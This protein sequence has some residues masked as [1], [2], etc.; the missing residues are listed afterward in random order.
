[1][2]DIATRAG[3]GVVAT[4][5][6]SIDGDG[7]YT[8]NGVALP[9]GVVTRGGSGDAVEWS[10]ELLKEAAE[11][12]NAEPM[13]SP[14][15]ID[16]ETGEGYPPDPADT[17]GRV[18]SAGYEPGVGVVYEA[19]LADAEIARKAAAGILDVSAVVLH[20]GKDP[21]D[22]GV[23][24]PTRAVFRGL[25]VVSKGAAPGN[26]I[27]MGESKQAALASLSAS[28]I[29]ERL[30]TGESEETTPDGYDA[31]SD[32]EQT[33]PGTSDGDSNMG[34]EN[35]NEALIQRIETLE[36]RVDEKD[37]KIDSLSADLESVESERDELSE[38]NESVAETLATVL[39]PHTPLST[40]EE[41]VEEYDVSTLWAKVQKLEDDVVD[42]LSPDVGS[43][44]G[45]DDGDDG[46]EMDDEQLE[47]L[48]K[49][50]GLMANMGFSTDRF[51]TEVNEEE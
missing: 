17:V 4:L 30:G 47:I 41:L 15:V 19:T 2:A 11:T 36:S 39:A 6:D 49:K 34:E 46:E 14:H 12:L 38:L 45:A 44:G 20:N 51:S 9:E 5:A 42:T 16:P 26:S 18:T 23:H 3:P 50:Q 28:T 21:D 24:R 35:Q 22:D 43:G 31:P 33:G 40:E 1:M 13:A 48:E 32:E 25:D 29:R 27:E 37:E 10:P 8:I 7:P